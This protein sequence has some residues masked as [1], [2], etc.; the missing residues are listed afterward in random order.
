MITEIGARL[1]HLTRTSSLEE[2]IE[3]LKQNNHPSKIWEWSPSLVHFSLK[4]A[5]VYF[6]TKKS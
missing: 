6:E 5:E 1:Y 3:S 2:A 4:E